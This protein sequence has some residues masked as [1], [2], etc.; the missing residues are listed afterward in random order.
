MSKEPEAYNTIST[1]EGQSFVDY[2]EKYAPELYVFYEQLQDQGPDAMLLEIDNCTQ[3]MINILQHLDENQDLP[4][5]LDVLYNINMMY[6][7]ISKYLLY[8]LKLFK[9][10][11]V[12]FI[13]EGLLLNYNENYNYQVN[14]DQITYDVNI[15]HHNRWNMSQYDWL[16][17]AVGTDRELCEKQRNQDALYMVT[18]YGDIKIS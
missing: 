6:G 18:R 11:R 2:L 17:P 5:L 7:G 13:S 16:E 15:T 8:I 1:V 9:A 3:F 10:W 12:E 14:V 4:D